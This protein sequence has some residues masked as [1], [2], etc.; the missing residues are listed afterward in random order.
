MGCASSTPM[1]ATAG[2]EMLK[3]ATHVKQKGEAAVEDASQTLTTTLDT[4]KE[5]VGTAVAGITN[6]LGNAFKEGTQALD[7][8]KHKVMEGLHLEQPQEQSQEAP[9][10]EEDGGATTAADVAEMSSSRAPTP[11]LQG[12]GDSLKTSTPEPEIERA[13][14]TEDESPPT[15]KP[16]LEEMVKLSAE[17]SQ[18]AEPTPSAAP[19]SEKPADQAPATESSAPVESRKVRRRFVQK[20]KSEKEQEQPRPSTTEWEKFADQLAKSKKFKPYE[21]FA[22]SHNKFSVYQD[23]TSLRDKPNHYDGHFSGG[24][25]LSA[26]QSDLSSGHVT[27]APARRGQREYAKFVGSEQPGSVSRNSSRLSNPAASR[28]FDFNPQRDRISLP[29]ATG[30]I[31][32]GIQRLPAERTPGWG[33]GRP[34]PLEE[35]PSFGRRMSLG[36]VSQPLRPDREKFTPSMNRR[37]VKPISSVKEKA[38]KKHPPKNISSRESSHLEF[39]SRKADKSPSRVAKPLTKDVVR[40]REPSYNEFDS[41]KGENIPLRTQNS[42][43]KLKKSP[44]KISSRE[45][46][47]M[48]FAS[49]TD[50]KSPLRTQKHLAKDVLRSREPSYT[51]FSSLKGERTPL[52]VGK[53]LG[54]N[55][56]R[57]REPSFTELPY[58]KTEKSP[59]RGQKAVQRSR[60]PSYTEF[61]SLKS[62]KTPSRAVKPL[63][64]NVVRSRE[65]SF[66]EIQYIK[67]EKKP[68]ATQA[69]RSRESSYSELNSCKAAESPLNIGK[70]VGKAILSSRE[71]SYTEFEATR[72]DERPLGVEKS[73]SKDIVRSRESSYLEFDSFKTDKIPSLS[74]DIMSSRDSSDIEF[75]SFKTPTKQTTSPSS[76]E[77]LH[78]SSEQLP[79]RQLSSSSKAQTSEY[80]NP[81]ISSVPETPQKNKTPEA[82]PSTSKVPS[83][84]T[85]RLS[86]A[87][88]SDSSNMDVV[89]QPMSNLNQDTP[90]MKSFSQS[91]DQ[92]V[93]EGYADS[94][95]EAALARLEILRGSTATLHS[96]RS[97]SP[98]RHTYTAASLL[99]SRRTSPWVMR[100][101]YGGSLVGKES[102]HKVAQPPSIQQTLERCDIC[103]NEFLLK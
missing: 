37:A 61:S 68:L 67:T 38:S 52:K 51:E 28:T 19:V 92:V 29:M 54:K 81:K 33:R 98:G 16:S 69:L 76:K 101:D 53:P 30:R 41:L 96:L 87:K 83:P 5:T 27:P 20:K 11:Q 59:L 47:Y 85:S 56:V 44:K 62:E 35:E 2:S 55:V 66:T 94:D 36:L 50:E 75:D 7:E 100:K 32:S 48:E 39:E 40:S 12:D 6:E 22:H 60:E 97:C 102:T 43:D 10:T 25:S 21:S 1:V 70:P 72:T 17:V 65:P 93:M 80:K 73:S 49:K 74:R 79:Q 78:A 89:I 45:S 3:A 91:P 84:S 9:P 14:A 86:S 90:S 23:H 64:R 4:A 13:L 15:P 95:L 99:S 57:S 103:S 71:P 24:N 46:T 34:A 8:A 58:Q 31:G 77:L 82:P 88:S 63:G 18:V 42:L 26:S